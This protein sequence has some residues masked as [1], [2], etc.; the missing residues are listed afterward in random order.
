MKI[1]LV[2]MGCGD[3]AGLTLMGAKALE[4]AEYILGARRLLQTLPEVCGQQRSA[5]YKTD[6]ILAEI[7]AHKN[8]QIGRAH[9]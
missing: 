1:T 2:G 7:Q 9:V 8:K 5:L 6:E 3:Y 4:D